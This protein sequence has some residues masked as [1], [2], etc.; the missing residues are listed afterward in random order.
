MAYRPARHEPSRAQTGNPVL[1]S[2]VSQLAAADAEL[3]ERVVSHREIHRGRYMLVEQEEIVRP[4][5]SQS[6]R[7]IVVHP[8]AVV[9]AALDAEERLLL[10]VQYRLAAGGALLELPAGTLDVQDGVVEEPEAAAR[11]ELEE[12]TG[13]RP[14]RLEKL[15]GYYSAPGFLTE[16]LSVYLATDLR[17][18]GRDRL[19]PDEDERIRLI[20]LPWRDA[21]AAVEAGVI[22][23][24]KS[25]G[26]IALL[27]RRLEG[28]Q[29][30]GRA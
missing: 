1:D 2:L 29:Q 24:A 23:D 26:A 27:A 20:R 10:V 22:E 17:P 19:D 8:G 13:Y 14:G 25:V 16:Y 5:G 7:D 3:E 6:S 15:A 18:A 30:P 9:I 12:E 21:M 28:H 4:D 11:R